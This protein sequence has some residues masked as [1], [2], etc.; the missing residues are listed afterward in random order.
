MEVNINQTF[1]LS[2]VELARSQFLANLVKSLHICDLCL[3]SQVNII[4]DEEDEDTIVSTFSQLSF[5][6]GLNIIKGKYKWLIMNHFIH[7][8][9]ILI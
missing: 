1:S 2:W 9:A 7:S 5:R 4:V 3:G 6:S 8:S